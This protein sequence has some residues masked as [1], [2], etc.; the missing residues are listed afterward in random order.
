MTGE[1][2]EVIYRVRVAHSDLDARV[3]AL[4]LEQTVEL[5]RSALRTAFVRDKIV[6]D[7]LSKEKVGP[8][9]YRVTLAQPAIAAAGDP[10]Q[11]LN[12]VFGNCSLQPEIELEDFR[13]PGALTA[14]LGGPRF[15]IDGLRR[16]TGVAARPLS[17]SVLKPVGLSVDETASLCHTLSLCGLDIVKDDHGL[18]DHGFNRFADRVAACV[19]ATRKA[20]QVTGQKTLYVPNLVGTPENVVRQAWQAKHLGAEAVMV[21]PMVVGLPFLNELAGE[22]GMPILAHPAFSGSLRIAPEALLGRLFRTFGADAVIFPNAGGRFSFSAKACG[23]IAAA[24]RAPAGVAAAFPVPAGGMKVENMASALAFYGPETVFL[25][26]GSLLDA[27]DS[28]SMLARG[29][30]FVESVQSFTAPP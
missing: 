4:L 16:L 18:G 1:A 2:I 26:G 24:L 13:L 7:V 17:A 19:A 15:G 5:P 29:R 14:K 23:G 20:A 21:S 22:I 30:A 3:D 27:P 10:A 12:L 8:G 9:D 25:I 11:L 28:N 6:G